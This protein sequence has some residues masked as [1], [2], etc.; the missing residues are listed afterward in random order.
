MVHKMDKRI[1]L[2]AP[3]GNFEKLKTAFRFGADAA[4]LG[5]KNFSLRSFADNFSAEELRAAVEYAHVRGKKVYVTANIFAKNADFAAL[6]DYFRYLQEIG[7]DAALVTDVGAF[8]LARQVAPEL[9]L[10]VSTQANTT[11]KYAAKF[12]QEQGAERVVLARELS[13]AE[14]SEL[15]EYC[16]GLELEAFVHGAMCISYSGRCLLSNYFAGRDSNRGECVQACRWKYSVRALREEGEGGEC[17]VEEDGRG[18][19]IFNSKDLNMLPHL[20]KLVGAGVCSFKIEGR[21]KSAYYLA[22]V[23]NAYRRALDGTLSVSEAQAELNKVA[24]R[25]FTTAYALGENAETVNYADSQ[26]SGTRAYVA[27]VLEDSA[28][29]GGAAG[30]RPG[31]SCALVQMRGRFR[32]GD[33]LEILSPSDSFN[34]A[35]VVEEMTDEAGERVEDAK[36]VMQKLRLRC[37]YP[38]AAGDLLRKV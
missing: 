14:I 1:E 25:A 24:H 5:G 23:V 18:S 17:A 27:D 9:P 10:H 34:R 30:G 21:M 8:S 26:E 7:A 6:A 28:P 11:N 13:L 19:Y 36:L 3:A 2:L 22:T 31:G 20:D 15:H 4:Y 32:V 35:F 33:T 12:W 16:P 38:L 29:C 37:P